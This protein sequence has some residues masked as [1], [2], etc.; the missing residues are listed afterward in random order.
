MNPHHT[1]FD[2]RFE[3]SRGMITDSCPQTYIEVC[4]AVKMIQSLGKIQSLSASTSRITYRVDGGGKRALS[5]ES[6]VSSIKSPL[7]E[8]ELKESCV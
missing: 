1:R 6:I 2:W 8:R 3:I 4:A 5:K 7:C